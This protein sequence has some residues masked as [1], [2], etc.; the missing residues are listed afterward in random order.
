M[1]GLAPPL[2][3]F[4]GDDD[5]LDLAGAFIDAED[6]HVAI[7]ALN[8]IVGDIAGPTKDLHGPVGDPAD[9]FRGI[10]FGSRR[11]WERNS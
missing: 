5:L 6:A 10:I 2:H 11:F 4:A 1:G 9:H 3:G 8:A 7:E